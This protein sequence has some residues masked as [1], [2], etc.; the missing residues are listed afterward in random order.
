MNR[1]LTKPT[2]S[3]VIPALNEEAHVADAVREITHAVEGRFADYELLCVDDGSTDRTGAI[4]DDL[5]ARD[6]RVKVTHNPTPKNLGGVYKQAIAMARFEYLVM[7]PGDNENPAS[8]LF[9]PFDA[10]GKADIVLPYPI[11]QKRSLFR[12]V[13]SRG[14]TT[15]MNGLFGLHVRYYNGTVIHRVD[16]LRGIHIETDSFAY[17]SEALIKLLRAGKSY[18]EVGIEIEPRGGRTSKALR[19]KNLIGVG[20]AIG[21]LLVEVYGRSR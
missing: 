1:T 21:G 17:Q 9:A 5:A 14:F 13:A 20:K 7:M 8:A 16:N 10:I 19:P 12:A 4:L 2:L 11:S 6:P 15:V 18:V 3:V